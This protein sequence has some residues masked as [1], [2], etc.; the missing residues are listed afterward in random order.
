MA[1]L[2]HLHNQAPNK[3]LAELQKML[4]EFGLKS[5]YGTI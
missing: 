1:G 5:V 4:L 2:I 3:Y